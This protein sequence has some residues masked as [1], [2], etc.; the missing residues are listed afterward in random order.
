M[1]PIFE[2]PADFFERYDNCVDDMGV[3]FAFEPDDAVDF[4]LH[5][6]CEGVANRLLDHLP[7]F[8]KDDAVTFVTES[9]QL[10]RQRKKQIEAGRKLPTRH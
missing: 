3:A 9:A 4:H 10:I 2:T 8:P 1:T 5:Q 6:F 7:K